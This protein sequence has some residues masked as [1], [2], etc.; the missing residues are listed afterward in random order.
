MTAHISPQPFDRFLES[1]ASTRYEDFRRLPG[2]GVE[3][4]AAFEEMQA[5]V[6]ELY[7]GVK[8]VESSVETDGQ[9]I[10]HIVADTHPAARRWGGLAVA[11]ADGPPQVPE[12]DEPTPPD[13]RS[14]ETVRPGPQNPAPARTSP[15]DTTPLYR[16][17]LSGLCRFPNLAAFSAKEKPFGLAAPAAESPVALLPNKRYATGE[18]DI[19]CLGGSS[20]VN[21]WSPFAA[22]SF[23]STFSQQWY[24][25]GHDGTLLQTVECGWHVD[26]ARYHDARPHLFVFANRDNYEDGDRVYNLDDGVFRPVTNPYVN[27]G[28][29]LFVSQSGGS[30]VEHRMGFFLTD[31]AWW[32]YFDDHPIGCFP[33]SWFNNGPLTTKATRARFGGE[34]GSAVSTW[35]PMGSGQHATAGFGQA[36]YQRT[37]TVFPVGGGAVYPNLAQAGSVTG[38]C[39]SLQITNNS[40]SYDWGTYLFFGGPGGNC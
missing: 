16:T 31:N 17:T 5:Y 40:V 38:T 30:Q 3:S 6:L 24:L 37:A 2:S 34:V 14:Q 21:V 32:F 25:A 28:S 33:V 13:P 27:P 10:D 11:P 36:A 26:I 18:L 9:V 20:R 35:P 8:A 29:P 4:S 12:P 19:D 15:A 1:V 22:P 39:Y 7:R 23:Q